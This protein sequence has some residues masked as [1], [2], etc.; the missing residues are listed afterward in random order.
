MSKQQGL[1]ACPHGRSATRVIQ[2]EGFLDGFG[3]GFLP[4]LHFG[5]RKLPE[6]FGF[7]RGLCP[8]DN[9]LIIYLR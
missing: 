5:G 1:Q 6:G 9:A 4:R 2:K 3:M 7:Q 8:K